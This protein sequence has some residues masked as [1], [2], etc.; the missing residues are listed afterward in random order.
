MSQLTQVAIIDHFLAK[1][2]K[3]FSLSEL[4]QLKQSARHI[5][6]LMAQKLCKKGFIKRL[7]DDYYVIL[8]ASEKQNQSVPAYHYMDALMQ[9]KAMPY[10]VGLLSAAHLHGAAHHRPMAFQIIT[11]QQ[12]R[13]PKK[14]LPDVDFHTKKQFPLQNIERHK[15]EY[16]TLQV[17]SPA[18]TIYDVLKYEAF[19]GGIYNALNVIKELLP[20]LKFL[21]L[22]TLLK[23]EL[24]SSVIRRMGFIFEK[25]EAKRYATLLEPFLSSNVLTV[26]LS[27]LEH[28]SGSKSA[29]WHIIDNVDWSNLDDL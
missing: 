28:T 1:G 22:K 3:T 21:D 2:Q 26:P 10:Y 16:G 13:T 5:A 27:K 4:A 17:A 29:K 8:S 19:A 9:H 15:G 23:N 25:L 14:F 20:Q 12:L 7:A 24:E 6:S 18:L 11:A